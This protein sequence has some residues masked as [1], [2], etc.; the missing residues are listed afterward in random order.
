MS[1][2]CGAGCGFHASRGGYCSVCFKLFNSGNP[3]PSSLASAHAKPAPTSAGK[4]SEL[5]A[6]E[7][8]AG[9]I[10]L[11]VRIGDLCLENVDAIVNAANASLD[12][13][14][15][16][17]GA[18][19]RHGGDGIQADSDAYLRERRNGRRLETG[20]AVA[21]PGH[22]LAS[23]WVVHAVG[24]IWTGDG[25]DEFMLDLTVRAALAAADAKRA[26]SISVP[27]IA[28]GIFGFPKPLC[29]K[30]MIASCRAFAEEQAK[31]P[32]AQRSSIKT[33]RLTNFDELTVGLFEKE[34]NATAAEPKPAS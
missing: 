25:T 7:T 28:S 13:A 10:T 34:L 24:P 11:E 15:G 23:R 21:L 32:E 1:D 26:T 14:A 27:A 22:Q 12:H 9:D 8:L 29:A 4:E 2:L 6:H 17:A 19:S 18:I 20:E 31:L 3:N 33:I 5:R 30:V 16:V